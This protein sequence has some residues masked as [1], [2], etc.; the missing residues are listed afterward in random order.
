MSAPLAKIEIDGKQVEVA[1]RA[2]EQGP[3]RGC[4]RRCAA[5]HRSLHEKVIR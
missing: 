5:E 1:V 2:A 4:D 3:Q